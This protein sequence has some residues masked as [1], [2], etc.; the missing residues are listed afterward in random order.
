MHA[1]W[2]GIQLFDGPNALEIDFIDTALVAPGDI[3]HLLRYSENNATPDPLRGGMH[4]NLFNNAWGTAFP[5]WY[6]DDGLIR[7]SFGS[8][9]LDC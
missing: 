9:C 3:D 4:S 5:Q 6:D 7:F 2:A 1:V 8:K